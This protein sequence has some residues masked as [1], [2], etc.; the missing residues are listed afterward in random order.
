MTKE[1]PVNIQGARAGEPA[2]AQPAL[3]GD[4]RVRNAE[5]PGAALRTGTGGRVDQHGH[6]HNGEKTDG[7][8]DRGDT[9]QGANQSICEIPLSPPGSQQGGEV[10]G[11]TRPH[12]GQIPAAASRRDAC[13]HMPLSWSGR[14]PLEKVRKIRKQLRANHGGDMVLQRVPLLLPRGDQKGKARGTQTPQE[15]RPRPWTNQPWT[16][17]WGSL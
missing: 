2:L 8:F 4:D 7:R 3:V 10:R 5:R 12:C 13:L 15:R 14:V 1:S 9:Q 17:S 11:Q 6:R 16:C